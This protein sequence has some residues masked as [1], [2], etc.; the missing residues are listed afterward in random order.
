MYKSVDATQV[1]IVIH[2]WIWLSCNLG[3]LGSKYIAYT[4][5]Q[6]MFYFNCVYFFNCYDSFYVTGSISYLYL[7]YQLIYGSYF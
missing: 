5:G 2:C 6:K 4:D 1:E 7:V 3:G